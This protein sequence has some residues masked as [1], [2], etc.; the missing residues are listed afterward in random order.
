MSTPETLPV[1]VAQSEPEAR[2]KFWKTQ[3]GRWT[4]I[5]LALGA[6]VLGYEY[7]SVLL[8]SSTIL[9]LPLLACV[10]MHFFMHKGHGGGHGGQ[11]NS[12]DDAS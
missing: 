3:S 8:T 6:L 2:P 11:R 9:F 10:G 5:A 12:G 1:P 7:R 4:L